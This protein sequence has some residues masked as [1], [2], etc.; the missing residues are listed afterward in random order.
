MRRVKHVLLPAGIVMLSWT[1]FLSVVFAALPITLLGTTT[2]S[3]QF[4][5]VVAIARVLS[6]YCPDCSVIV[7]ESGGGVDATQQ[8]RSGEARIGNS[9]A[10][11]DSQSYFGRGVLFKDK[12]FRDIRILW[13][14]QRALIQIVV[15][16]DSGIKTLQD[17]DG[18]PFSAGG[19]GTT[20][21]S[22]IHELFD[23]L[24]IH[25]QYYESGQIEATDAY[26]KKEV[27]GVVKI[28]PAPDNYIKYLNDSRPVRFLSIS[29]EDM[30]KILR[31]IPGARISFLPINAYKN[32]DYEVRCLATYHGLQTDMSFSQEEGYRFFKAMWEDG[33]EIWQQAYP[34][35]KD[36]DI[37][38]LTLDAAL[39]PLHA[40]TVQYLEVHDYYVPEELIPE[41]Y[42]PVR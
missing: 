6:T 24:D 41:E 17:L 38:K 7:A 40:G 28:G 8:I 14:Y 31:G 29:R 30:D 5:Y 4:P 12:P 26:I 3:G 13:Y 36:N 39:T 18:R 42:V 2:S 1:V 16:Q 33:K 9:I 37:P 22:I 35:G 15:A 27:D 25:P 19:T 21:S 23:I 11:T 20:A 10:Y 34:I 32:V